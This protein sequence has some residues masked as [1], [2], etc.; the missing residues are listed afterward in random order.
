MK[1]FLSTVLVN[2]ALLFLSPCTIE[3]G[4]NIRLKNSGG[5]LKRHRVICIT[6]KYIMNSR[7]ALFIFVGHKFS[8]F[9][10]PLRSTQESLFLSYSH[11]LVYTLGFANYFETKLSLEGGICDHTL[12]VARTNIC[13]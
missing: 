4:Y 7:R 2:A 6:R 5:P 12:N 10:R 13:M 9:A 11:P 3:K 1:L 8:N